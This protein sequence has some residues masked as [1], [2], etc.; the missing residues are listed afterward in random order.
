MPARNLLGEGGRA[1]VPIALS[2]TRS[3]RGQ[4]E[5][6]PSRVRFVG[7]PRPLA[8]IWG[9]HPAPSASGGRCLSG[10]GAQR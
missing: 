3:L 8:G 7:L 9:R 1:G 10:V 6:G 5:L 4:R 2:G